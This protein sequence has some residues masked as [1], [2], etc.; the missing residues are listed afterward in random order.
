M[1]RKIDPNSKSIHRREYMRKYRENRKS[2]SMTKS[3]EEVY[4]GIFSDF[5]TDSNGYIRIKHPL[6]GT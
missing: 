5:K 4:P 3:V 1:G 2:P 6:Q